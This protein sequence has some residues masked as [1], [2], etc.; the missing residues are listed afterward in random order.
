VRLDVT[1]EEDWQHVVTTAVQRFGKL[2]ILVNNTGISQQSRVEHTIFR[3][4]GCSSVRRPHMDFGPHR[5]NR[6]QRELL[7]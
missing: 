2:D 6:S 4:A 7:E 5:D 3:Y 1:R